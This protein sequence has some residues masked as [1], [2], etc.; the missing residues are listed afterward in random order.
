M[1]AKVGYA[2]LMMS[3][4]MTVS[5]ILNTKQPISKT[6]QKLKPY[7]KCEQI[8]QKEYKWH[9]IAQQQTSIFTSSALDKTAYMDQISVSGSQLCF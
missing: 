5:F 9:G 2:K 1:K 7:D 6:Q 4:H 3:K 8:Q